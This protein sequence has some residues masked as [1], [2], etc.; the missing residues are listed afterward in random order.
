MSIGFLG[1]T[2]LVPGLGYFPDPPEVPTGLAITG[3]SG[4]IV[5]DL[6]PE[7]T[8]NA[9]DGASYYEVEVAPT[10]TL[11]GTPDDTPVATTS[12]TFSTLT[13][14][15]TYDFAVRA[16]NAGGPGPWATVT[17]FVA[18]TVFDFSV[19]PDGALP[20]PLT[21]STWTI[22]SGVAANTPT[23]G[24]EMFTDPGMENWAS[25]TN[26]T[27][28]TE[29]TAGTSTHNQDSTAPHG[30]TY[31]MRM[32]I[33][34]AGSRTETTQ[35]VART[36]GVWYKLRAWVKGSAAIVPR[37]FADNQQPSATLP[38]GVTTSWLQ[39]IGGYLCRINAGQIGVQSFGNN[40]LSIH[41]DDLSHKALTTTELYAY[42]PPTVADATV[43]A[44]WTFA[45][46]NTAGAGILMNID[47]PANPQNYVAI[48]LTG[49]NNGVWVSKVVNGTPGASQ[50]AALAAAYSAGAT[51]EV[52]KT[53]TNY[54]VYY[55]GSQIDG[56][57]GLTIS[58]ASIINNTYHG[59][60]S[61][62]SGNVCDYFS[63]APT[64]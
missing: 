62:D 29:Y 23:E 28:W 59:L 6:T 54:K 9:V 48:F 35:A 11:T 38:A 63:S 52:R 61:L 43:K 58:D 18:Y 40:N 17:V 55:N 33:G 4:G 57:S 41:C 8:W 20:A 13:N 22:A 37:L 7:L 42:I 2:L 27:S 50:V 34:A 36:P 44:D 15:T 1:N 26:L 51:L 19:E 25:A 47:D 24:A 16:V 14:V 3:A 12:Y 60:F 46:Q 10:G 30:G 21:G 5:A 56:G 49:A 39:A 45:S 53:G 64:A 32:D 31:N